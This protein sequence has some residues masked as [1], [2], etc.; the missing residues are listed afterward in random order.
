MVVATVVNT[1]A[2]QVGLAVAVDLPW[3]KAPNRFGLKLMGSN[4]MG[5]LKTD[6]TWSNDLA[7]L[8]CQ[9]MLMA[10]QQGLVDQSDLQGLELGKPVTISGLIRRRNTTASPQLAADADSMCELRVCKCHTVNRLRVSYL[11]C[12]L[13]VRGCQTELHRWL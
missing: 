8:G 6:D 7:S 11:D 10:M 12:T 3:D 5:A 13:R 2:L 4:P 9:L 1:V